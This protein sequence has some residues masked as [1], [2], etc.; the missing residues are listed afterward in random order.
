MV[1][2]SVVEVV[3]VLLVPR[4]QVAVKRVVQGCLSV[5][6]DFFLV[7][8]LSVRV[9]LVTRVVMDWGPRRRFV[10]FC[11]PVSVVWLVVCLLVFVLWVFV[12]CLAV[13]LW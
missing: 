6:C 8:F 1:V 2:C 7:L 10:P 3:V 5:C 12:V 11:L 9:A 13:R 4:L